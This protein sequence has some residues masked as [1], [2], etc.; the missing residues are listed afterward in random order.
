MLYF[1][2]AAKP[3]PAATAE[4]HQTKQRQLP[5]MSPERQ[6]CISASKIKISTILSALKKIYLLLLVL[7]EPNI[8]IKAT[9]HRMH[10]MM[11]QNIILEISS[12]QEEM[13]MRVQ[14]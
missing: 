14:S 10:K 9:K 12:H 7:Q 2:I 13:E 3:P 5:K 11:F 8:F 6:K 4:K 1:K